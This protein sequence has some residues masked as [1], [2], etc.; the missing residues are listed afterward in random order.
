M[1]KAVQPVESE[2]S[3][4]VQDI[5]RLDFDPDGLPRIENLSSGR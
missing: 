3:T 5:L 4:A 1:M 2:Q